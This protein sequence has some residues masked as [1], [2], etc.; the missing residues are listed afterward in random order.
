MTRTPPGRS[1]SAHGALLRQ[2]FHQA[3]PV[4]DSFRQKL[5]RRRRKS[6]PAVRAAEQVEPLP[7]DQ[8]VLRTA[9]KRHAAG[10]VDRIIAAELGAVDLWSGAEDGAVALV[11]KTPD[12]AG[13]AE[14]E[15]G[16]P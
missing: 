4:S 10:D 6:V 12:H 15:S 16:Q 1:S 3:G 2:R 9:G 13:R 7:V 5:L 11:A 14:L 8:P